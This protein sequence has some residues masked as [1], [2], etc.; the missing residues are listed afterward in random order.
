M[1]Q[2]RIRLMAMKLARFNKAV[3]ASIGFGEQLRWLASMGLR[4]PRFFC[5]FWGDRDGLVS[6]VFIFFRLTVGEIKQLQLTVADRFGAGSKLS[7][8]QQTQLLLTRNYSFILLR[9]D[10]L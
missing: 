10:L 9:N 7:R 5:F 4:L 2:E 3:K 1:L 6:S 8:E